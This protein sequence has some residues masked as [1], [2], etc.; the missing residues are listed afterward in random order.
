MISLTPIERDSDTLAE[1]NL[2]DAVTAIRKDGFVVI[3][4]VVDHAHL[5][6]LKERMDAD[7]EKMIAAAKWGGAGRLRGHLQQGP[8]PYDPFLFPDVVVN[9]FAVQISREMLGD[10]FYCSFYNGNTN[11]PGS[12]V[13]PLHAD[14][15]HLWGEQK[16]SHPAAQLI[17]NVT[18]Q[19]ASEENGA[20]QIWPGSHLDMRPVNDETEADRRSFAPAIQAATR[21]GDILIRDSR[22]WH[23]GV[24]NPSD[25]NRH[26][27]ATVFNI[28]WMVRRRTLFF[29]R[30]G[31]GMFEAA[32]VDANAEF[33]D[34][35]FE[36]LF[37]MACRKLKPDPM[38]GV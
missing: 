25:Q 28:G 6:V 4:Q 20:T 5:D 26:M 10:G 37:E 16:V 9:P 14:G 32:G 19:D 15:V 31:E 11:T 23:R 30:G 12:E 34:P 27:I 17:V 18:P 22:L 3:E 36:Y 21:K 35:P 13:Q 1:D 2:A 24:S 29:G 33:A 8:P 38:R 7:S